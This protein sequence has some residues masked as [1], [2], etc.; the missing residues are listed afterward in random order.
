MLT[1]ATVRPQHSLCVEPS[2]SYYHN[3]GPDNFFGN[4]R[5]EPAALTSLVSQPVT[6]LTMP[7]K[8][9]RQSTAQKKAPGTPNAEAFSVVYILRGLRSYF[10]CRQALP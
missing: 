7:P 10:N 6:T 9:Q 3:C 2:P 1:A 8:T 4:P 5:T